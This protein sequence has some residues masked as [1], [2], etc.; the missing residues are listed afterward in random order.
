MFG[1]HEDLIFYNNISQ[2][3]TVIEEFKRPDFMPNERDLTHILFM[4]KW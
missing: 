3:K 2:L 4:K 1:C